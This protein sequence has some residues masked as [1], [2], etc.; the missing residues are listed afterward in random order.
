MEK[1][2]IIARGVELP[3]E[4]MFAAHQQPF[5]LGGTFFFPAHQ[6][7]VGTATKESDDSKLIQLDMVTG[8]MLGNHVGVFL[9][10]TPE[11][12]REL[13][14]RLIADAQKVDN[15]VAAQAAAVIETARIKGRS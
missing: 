5:E 10:M 6:F 12:A 9:R 14:G 11:G 2:H 15:H 4:G 8:S 7:Q 3:S 13:A 1:G